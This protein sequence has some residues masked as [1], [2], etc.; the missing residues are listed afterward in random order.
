MLLNG[1]IV[2]YCKKCDKNKEFFEFGRNK[3]MT[4]GLS[5]Y[6]K[7]CV[8]ILAKPYQLAHKKLY[9]KK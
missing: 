8:Q 6:C 7:E 9:K 4:D 2:K 1:G 5:F 3:N